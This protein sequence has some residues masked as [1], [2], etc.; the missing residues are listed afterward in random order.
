MTNEPTDKRTNRQMD[1]KTN[2]QT[3]KRKTYEWANGK[4]D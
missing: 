3:D 2:G 1:R 4:M